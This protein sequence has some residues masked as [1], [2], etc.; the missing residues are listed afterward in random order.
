MLNIQKKIQKTNRYYST[1]NRR[2]SKTNKNKR[3]GIQRITT[4]FTYG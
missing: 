1:D 2:L 3:E 4:G